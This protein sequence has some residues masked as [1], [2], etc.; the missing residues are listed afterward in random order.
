MDDRSLENF[1][2]FSEWCKQSLEGKSLPDVLRNLSRETIPAPSDDTL[3]TVDAVKL[4][5]QSFRGVQNFMNSSAGQTQN[6]RTAPKSVR[7]HW[8]S[9]SAWMVYLD[10]YCITR[11]QFGETLMA[12]SLHAIALTSAAISWHPTIRDAITQTSGLVSL[13]TRHW[14]KE[15]EYV[16]QSELRWE[17]RYFAVALGRLFQYTTD[18]SDVKIVT[19]ITKAGGG[20]SAVTQVSLEQ[21]RSVLKTEKVDFSVVSFYINLIHQASKATP[22]LRASLLGEGLVPAIAQ[23]IDLLPMRPPATVPPNLQQCIKSCILILVLF[24]ETANGPSFIAEAFDA[25]LLKGFLRLWPWLVACRADTTL[26]ERLFN[27]LTDYLVYRSVLRSLGK[28]LKKMDQLH[29]DASLAQCNPWLAFRDAASMQLNI[30]K[31]FDARSGSRLEPGFFG[32]ENFDVS[33]GFLSHLG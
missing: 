10:I 9:I 6:R 29:I 1:T 28:A 2:V 16:C 24:M 11:K 30:K 3:S 31:N 22:S 27:L 8:R 23:F 4:A 20:P 18:N 17:E 5:L 26:S 32:C 25:G 21:L 7:A 15:D 12:A 14:T 33:R 13:L 19:F